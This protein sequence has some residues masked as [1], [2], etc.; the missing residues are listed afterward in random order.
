MCGGFQGDGFEGVEAL[1]GFEVVSVLFVQMKQFIL[2]VVN[3]VTGR[4]PV[5]RDHPIGI[6]IGREG[7]EEGED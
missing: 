5:W 3:H 6:E 4:F 2:H 1:I 7:A